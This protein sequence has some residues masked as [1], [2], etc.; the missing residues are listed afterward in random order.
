MDQNIRKFIMK[1]FYLI[2]KLI[3]EFYYHLDINKLINN[4]FN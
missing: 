2:N 1:N 4:F 3:I